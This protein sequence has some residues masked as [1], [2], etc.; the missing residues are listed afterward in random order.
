MTETALEV[1]QE[2]PGYYG[3]P[4]IHGPHW[5]WLI[6]GYFYA[7]G[8]S[9]GAAAL[10]AAASLFGGQDQARLRD[11]A[12]LVSFAALLPCP[13][14]L[15]LDL[16]RPS[17]FLNMV[18]AFRPSSPMSM[19]TWG[20]NA[21]ATLE[22]ACVAVVIARRLLG[23]R[24]T[25]PRAAEAAL[26]AA[27]GAAGLFLA[28]Y[29]GTL[30]AATAVP[31]WAKRPALLGPLFLSSA[32]SSACAATR[33]ALLPGQHPSDES[34]QALEIIDVAASLTKAAVLATWLAALGD[35]ARPL[36][37]GVRGRLVR[38]GC[39]L[40]GV[41]APL[42]I[43]AATGRSSRCRR[44]GKATAALLSLAGTFAL[45]YAVVSGGRASANDP[46]ATFNL[47]R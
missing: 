39:V 32:I 8:I 43:E 21:F 6:I 12:T 46:R 13:V 10:A 23:P 5:N 41:A 11:H 45:R 31:L 9:G 22:T 24:A 47:A 15:I 38:D 33:L 2:R 25:P 17:R 18:R 36:T 26:Q 19:G 14:L 29:T 44:V 16:G 40:A 37:D 42:L 34:E 4:A 3:Q 20:L 30:L 35:E 7:G 1:Q 28:G 27:T